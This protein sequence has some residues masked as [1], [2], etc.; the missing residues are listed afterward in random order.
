[1]FMLSSNPMV[2]L[3]NSYQLFE[4][5]PQKIDFKFLQIIREDAPSH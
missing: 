3:H 4:E 5:D 2:N 1:M